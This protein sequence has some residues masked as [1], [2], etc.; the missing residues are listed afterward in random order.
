MNRHLQE[1]TDAG[2]RRNLTSAVRNVLFL[3]C[4]LIIL[5][6]I[7]YIGFS[8]RGKYVPV[9]FDLRG[10]ILYEWAP[11]SFYQEGPHLAG[12]NNE[13]GKWN[14]S[15]RKIFYPLWY[16]DIHYFHKDSYDGKSPG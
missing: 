14:F 10:I 7:V 3:I 12:S 8:M 9:A 13:Y 11:R 2:W 6:V 5:Y 4:L 16:V 15:T 1:N